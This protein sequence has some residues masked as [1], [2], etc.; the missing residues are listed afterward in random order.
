[1]GTTII[2]NGVEYVVGGSVSYEQLVELACTKGA[3]SIAYNSP[4]TSGVRRAG[5][6]TI[7]QRLNVDDRMSFTV[8]HTGNA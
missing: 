7:G 4:R 6:L 2:V 1:M 5:T 3:P 8:V